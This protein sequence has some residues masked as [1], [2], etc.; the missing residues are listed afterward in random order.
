MKVGIIR[1]FR[2]VTSLV[3]Y[4]T[5]DMIRQMTLKTVLTRL[6]MLLASISLIAWIQLSRNGQRFTY[7]HSGYVVEG[8]SIGF[9]AS[10]IVSRA[11]I[12]LFKNRRQ[13]ANS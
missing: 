2:S 7:S 8:I 4:V 13:E 9:M 11:V 10:A 3:V 1:K 6:L 12:W 5:K